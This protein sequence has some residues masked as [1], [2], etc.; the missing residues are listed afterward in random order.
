MRERLGP[1]IDFGRLN[2]GETRVS[3]CATD[4][5]SGDAVLFD[6][7]DGPLEMDHLLASCGFLPEFAPVDVDGGL[8]RWRSV[9]GRTFRSDPANEW[10][11]PAVRPVL[12]RRL[13]PHDDRKPR[14]SE[15]PT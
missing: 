12:P 4:M 14:A 1:L 9:G 11:D 8:C 7:D 10:P 5:E 15:K 3:I 2:S 13:A 6:T